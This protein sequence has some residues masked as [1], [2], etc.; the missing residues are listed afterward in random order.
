MYSTKYELI[1]RFIRTAHIRRHDIYLCKYAKDIL[2]LDP[3]FKDVCYMWTKP[4][5]VLLTPKD[6]DLHL[7]RDSLGS[8]IEDIDYILRNSVL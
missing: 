8:V 1:R 3:N 4:E 6:V 7:L 2:R 5:C